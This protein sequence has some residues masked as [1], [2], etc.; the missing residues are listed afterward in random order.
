VEGCPVR[1]WLG[2]D[3]E[4]AEPRRPLAARKPKYVSQKWKS[5]VLCPVRSPNAVTPQTDVG[6]LPVLSLVLILTARTESG[7]ALQ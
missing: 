3:I 5:C 6:A 4:E 2:G 7:N 1:L